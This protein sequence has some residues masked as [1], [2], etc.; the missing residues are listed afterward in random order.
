VAVSDPVAAGMH[1]LQVHTPANSMEN[2]TGLTPS[3]CCH[4]A[5]G[6]GHPPPTTTRPSRAC[7]GTALAMR[8]G[9]TSQA[10]QGGR[11]MQVPPLHQPHGC[12]STPA[13]QCHTVLLQSV[14]AKSTTCARALLSHAR[15]AGA[16]VALLLAPSATVYTQHEST[17]SSRSPR[18]LPLSITPRHGP[19]HHPLPWP[20]HSSRTGTA[21]NSQQLGT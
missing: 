3:P 10:S 16:A 12:P 18:S 15:P 17:R 20:S 5:T 8:Q 13:N 4:S 11:H 7:C 21:T 19:L 14:A 6:A 1:R 9:E 2:K